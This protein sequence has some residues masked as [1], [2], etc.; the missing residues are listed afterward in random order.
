MTLQ[1]SNSRVAPRGEASRAASQEADEHED[2]N[3]QE[4]ENPSPSELG[5]AGEDARDEPAAVEEEP[6]AE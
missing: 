4:A 1:R 2:V 5:D 3:E 6:A